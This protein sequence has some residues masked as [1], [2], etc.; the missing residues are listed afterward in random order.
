[1]SA[2]MHPAQGGGTGPVGFSAYTVTAA[3]VNPE[4]AAS[5]PAVMLNWPAPPNRLPAT[6]SEYVMM[7]PAEA[8]LKITEVGP[9][10]GPPLTEK[11]AGAV[12][13]EKL[14]LVPTA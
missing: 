11:T 5:G 2:A 10:R 1:M 6:R 9:G 13:H 14:R 4:V 8:P 3:A 7:L 12:G